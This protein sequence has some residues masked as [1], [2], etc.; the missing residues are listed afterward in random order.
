MC[1]DTHQGTFASIL[2]ICKLE[3]QSLAPIPLFLE[4]LP[5]LPIPSPWPQAG[6]LVRFQACH[7][8]PLLRLLPSHQCPL[9]LLIKSPSMYT[10]AWITRGHLGVYPP[11][12]CLHTSLLS[13]PSRPA[14]NP[15]LLVFKSHLHSRPVPGVGLGGGAA[16]LLVLV[17]HQGISSENGQP[18]YHKKD[19]EEYEFVFL[20]G[21][22]QGLVHCMCLRNAF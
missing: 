7:I 4:N 22:S 5:P 9:H 17:A 15:R 13:I 19:P 18:P 1:K 11:V 6:P 21:T 10:R 2:V 8:P 3:S 12:F 16:Q 20:S 14:R